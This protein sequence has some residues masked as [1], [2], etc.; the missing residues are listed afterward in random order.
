MPTK[1]PLSTSKFGGTRIP[2]ERMG[3]LAPLKYD[4]LISVYKD[5]SVRYYANEHHE[6]VLK[7]SD[8]I[9]VI[10][11]GV[12]G[13][14]LPQ[15]IVKDVFVFNSIYLKCLF[16]IRSAMAR[17]VKRS[18]FTVSIY[19]ASDATLKPVGY[20]KTTTAVELALR[21]AL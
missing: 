7:K 19:R 21:A 16:A 5:G 2:Y 6:K 11:N 14:T 4:E 10:Y 1:S 13:L 17:Y 12:S 20:Y 3:E 18:F 15:V 8:V 9:A